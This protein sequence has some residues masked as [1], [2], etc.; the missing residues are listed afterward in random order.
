MAVKRTRKIDLQ[1]RPEDM[2]IFVAIGRARTLTEAA[3]VLKVP[4]FTASRALKR[5]EH[6]AQLALIRRGESGLHLTEVGQEYLKACQSV[7]LAHQAAMEVLLARQMEPQGVLHVAA[8]V[9]FAQNVLS[10]V[11]SEF[12]SSFPKL[13]VELSLYC[14]DWNQEPKA[15]HDVFF[16]VRA[17]EESRHQMK[18]FP[19]IRQ[20]LFASPAYLARHPE[21]RHP[22]DLES[23]ECLAF[24]EAEHRAYWKFWKNGEHLS[25]NPATRIVVSDPYVLA[26]LAVD[27]AGVSVIPLWVAREH[28]NT[29]A[30]VQML[31]EWTV[32]PMFFCALYSGRPRPASKEGAFLSYM[33][34][35][36][37]GPKDPRC[38]G[39][40]P[41]EFFVHSSLGMR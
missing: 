41:N 29:G 20:G 17:P 5:I 26:R 9:I 21:L 32:E 40:D 18:L 31:P 12:L 4:L 33:A 6:T 1:I 15:A 2:R 39:L 25:V 19:P 36:L 3:E 35:I 37:G 30:L 34:S 11:L 24:T 14:S 22:V 10:H 27:S 38:A 7:L 23:H 28:V 16:K 8:P 13:R